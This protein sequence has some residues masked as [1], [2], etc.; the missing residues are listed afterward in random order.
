MLTYVRRMA[1]SEISL[2]SFLPENCPVSLKIFPVEVR[3][4]S[5]PGHIEVPVYL[6]LNGT[7]T[8]EV[9]PVSRWFR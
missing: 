2:T 5:L 7:G 8:L 1:F 3:N 9:M 6:L 4:V